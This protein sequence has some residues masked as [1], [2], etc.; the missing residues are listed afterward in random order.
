MKFSYIPTNKSTKMKRLVLS[1]FFIGLILFII[2]GLKVISFKSII[3]AVSIIPFIIAIMLSSRYLIRV[4]SYRIEDV[5]EGLELFVDEITRSS[6]YTVCRLELKKLLLVAPLKDY[7]KEDRKKRRYD[8]RADLFE[9]DSYV[10]EFSDG[11]YDASSEKIRIILS[12]NEEMLDI[13]EK[14]LEENKQITE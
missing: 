14:I 4:H 2:G 10:L 12:A 6:A 13:L 3:Q 7:P 9:K 1:L 5:G 11:T 8:Y